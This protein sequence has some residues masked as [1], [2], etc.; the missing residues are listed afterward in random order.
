MSIYRYRGSKVWTMDFM[1]HAQRIRESTGTRS[2]TL[3]QKIEDK[4]R[5]ELEEGTAG[6]RKRQQPQLLSIASEA[7]L[8]MKKSSLSPKTVV[9]EKTNLA[10]LLP[11]LGRK[12]VVDIDARD[13]AKYQQ[14]RLAFGASPKTINL[15]IGTLRAI[16]RRQG[17][18]AR[19]QQDVR[20]LPTREDVGRAITAEEERALL[21]ACAKSRSRSLLPFVTLAIETGAR[22]GVIRTLQWGNIHFSNRCLQ[23]GKDKTPSGTGRIIPLNPR[24]MATLSFWASHFPDC[25]PE[26]YVFPA[27]RYGAAGNKFEP[28]ACQTGPTQPIQ[29]IKEAWET[30]KLRAAKILKGVPEENGQGEP[31]ESGEANTGEKKIEP[32]ACRFHDLR[33]TAVS[34]MLDAGV[35]IA[36]VAKIVGWSPATMVR[37]AARY[38]HFAL[39]ELRSAV[40]SISRAEIQQRS[41]VIPPVLEHISGSERTN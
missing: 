34:R 25:Q 35:P 18:W 32:F 23:F 41:P 3:A 8:E 6:I 21:E 12:L 15:E 2:K 39:E 27:E 7:W 14:K 9:I 26:H 40:E 11:E 1:F 29:S 30:A 10:H 22:F 16:L 19:L 20:M 5:R 33:H 4:R 37:M 38:G 36:K 28:K 31:V 13:I 24:A 17:I